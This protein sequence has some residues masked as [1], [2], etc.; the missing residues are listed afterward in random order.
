VSLISKA[1]RDVLG[2][3]NGGAVLRAVLSGKAVI[4]EGASGA[5]YVIY[6]SRAIKRP[7]RAP[8]A[9]QEARQ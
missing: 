9:T 7:S 4:V 5:R 6:T 1:M 8:Q 3:D 2:G